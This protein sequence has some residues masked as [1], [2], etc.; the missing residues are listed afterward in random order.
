MMS[1]CSRV[2]LPRSCCREGDNRT[3]GALGP[4]V[5]TQ[6]RTVGLVGSLVPR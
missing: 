5:I 6:S 4:L 3:G 1:S 2:D